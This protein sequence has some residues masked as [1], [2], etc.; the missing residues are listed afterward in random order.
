MT[1]GL[2][3]IP[4]SPKNRRMQQ[5]AHLLMTRLMR[6]KAAPPKTHSNAN[7]NT[8]IF[9]QGSGDAGTGS[10]TGHGTAQALYTT[11]AAI[12]SILS[13]GAPLGFVPSPAGIYTPTRCL[14]RSPDPATRL[15]PPL[16]DSGAMPTDII[17]CLGL[18]GV[19]P[20][21]PM[22]PDG[23]F[24]DV[25]VANV[26]D[27]P[28]LYALEQSGM[29]IET[30]SYRLDETA[31]NVFDQIITCI[32]SGVSVGIGFFCDTVFMNWNFSS[33]G[34][35]DTVDVMDTQGGGHWVSFDAY[36]TT[37][38]GAYVLGG[39]NSWGTAWG[40][41]GRFEVTENWFRKAVSDAIPFA[42]PNLLKEAA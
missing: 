41:R 19:R 7:C 13:I 14:E 11:T 3:Y 31:P 20:I 39:P 5:P 27:E 38:S 1:F 30:G 2:G 21:G 42:N 9:D 25:T 4:D 34:P 36:D 40:I 12:A 33:D 35:I 8:S 28:D 16:T 24:S 32:A 18:I 17:T 22:A 10:C 26:N 23:R 37:S 6:A 29:K 15:L